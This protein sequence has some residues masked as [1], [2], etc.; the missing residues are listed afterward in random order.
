MV[1]SGSD[2]ARAGVANNGDRIAPTASSN[3][4]RGVAK[5]HFVILDSFI[6]RGLDARGVPRYARRKSEFDNRSSVKQALSHINTM[7]AGRSF[8]N[9]GRGGLGIA[10]Q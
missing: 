7:G 1:V 4:R 8:V 5:K 6:T 3:T 2:W 10:S 9:S